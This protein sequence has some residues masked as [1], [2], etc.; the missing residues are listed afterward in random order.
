M[1]LKLQY[2]KLLSSFA[3]NFNLRRYDVGLETVQVQI[4]YDMVG[5]GCQSKHST[6]DESP[7]PPPP[8][9]CMSVH[10]DVKS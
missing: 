1:R 2:D 3:F 6:D 7:P 9:L 5:V 8:C 4:F 10:P